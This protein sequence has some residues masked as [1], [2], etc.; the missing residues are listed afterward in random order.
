M[1]LEGEAEE[2][3]V[4]ESILVMGVDAEFWG[5]YPCGCVFKDGMGE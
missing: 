5:D 1:I 4:C 3:A 2:V